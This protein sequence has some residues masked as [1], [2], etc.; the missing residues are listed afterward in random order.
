MSP[1]TPSEEERALADTLVRYPMMFCNACYFGDPADSEVKVNNG[2]MTLISRNSKRFGI[3][4]YHVIEEYRNR[5]SEEPNIRFCVGNAEIDVESAILDEDQDLD[6]CT[7]CFDEYEEESFG[8][9]GEVPTRFLEIESFENTNLQEGSFVLLG[10]Y[11]GVWRE[12]PSSNHLIFDTLSSGGMEVMDVSQRNI[13]CELALDKCVVSLS[14]H[15]DEFPNNL[16]GLSGGPVFF[17]ELSPA[18]ISIFKF[19]GVI[20]EFMPNFDSILIRPATFIDSDF[21]IK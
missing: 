8:S 10:G 12:R 16:G 17:H 15:R 21:K 7:F 19:V 2:T 5:R 14:D 11:P 3:T 9:D 13:R 6:L 18:G 4:N 20:Y 1:S